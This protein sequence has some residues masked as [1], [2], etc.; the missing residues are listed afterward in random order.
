MQGSSTDWREEGRPAGIPP[1]FAQ[2]IRDR[3]AALDMPLTQNLYGPLL[4]AQRRDGVQ[5]TSNLAYG[6]DPRHRLDVYRSTA[7]EDAPRPVLLFLHGGG[8]VRGDKSEKENVGQF[9]AREGFV[10]AIANYRLAPQVEWPAGAQDVVSAFVWLQQ[11]VVG[12]GGDPRRIFLAGE[13]AGAAHVAAAALL[14][15]LHPSG[16]L[17]V[18]G[19]VLISG[20][21]NVELERMARRQFGV[22]TPDPRNDAYFGTDKG[23]HAVMSVVRQV[24][25]PPVPM[26]I[27][28]AELDM[29]QMQ[30]QAGELF[31]TLVV[32]HGFDPDLLV[33][34]GHNH[35]TQVYSINTGDETLSAPVSAFLRR[36]SG[37]MEAGK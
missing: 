17:P 26:L 1:E 25:A 35:L 4:S 33:V 3:G 32:R 11:H 15:T 14:R 23:R 9:F 2:R 30:V 28:Y 19:V 5:V 13:S 29:P 34:R 7:D 8:F 18:A 20:V 16:G 36:H 27:S 21:Y 24:D 6:T 22:A 12:L 10:V 37:L 31:A